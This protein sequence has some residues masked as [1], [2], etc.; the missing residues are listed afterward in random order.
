MV[1]QVIPNAIKNPRMI[2]VQRG[3]DIEE[4]LSGKDKIF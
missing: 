4:M 3:I 2:S 1:S